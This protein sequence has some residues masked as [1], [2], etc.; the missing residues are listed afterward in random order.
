MYDGIG[1]ARHFLSLVVFL[2]AKDF[3]PYVGGKGEEAG[4][5]GPGMMV[6]VGFDACVCV[7]RGKNMGEELLVE[8]ASS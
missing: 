1:F 5:V 3:V 2:C 8:S 7:Q 4:E 6:K